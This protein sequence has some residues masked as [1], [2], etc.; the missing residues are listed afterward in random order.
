MAFRAYVLQNDVSVDSSRP[1]TIEELSALGLKVVTFND[2]QDPEQAAQKLV[3]EWGYP[4]EKE[5]CVV[6]VDLRQDAANSPEVK[7]LYLSTIPDMHSYPQISNLLA[8]LVQLI[9]NPW[10]QYSYML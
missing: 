9:E 5:D 4:L 1:V 6:P 10:A 7:I 3:Q 2:S 8:Q